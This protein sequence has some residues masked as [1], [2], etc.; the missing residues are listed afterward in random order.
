M[1]HIKHINE[2]NNDNLYHKI[3][4]DEW[5]SNGKGINVSD[6]VYKT[7]DNYV[8]SAI[9]NYKENKAGYSYIEKLVSVKDYSFIR[10]TSEY[11]FIYI[12][13][14]DD[15]YFDISVDDNYYKCDTVQ[16]VIN[17]LKG[18]S[19]DKRYK[20]TNESNSEPLYKEIDHNMYSKLTSDSK[21]FD[22]DTYNKF[23]DKYNA[24][25]ISTSND[26][27]RII[28]LNSEDYRA[29]IWYLDDEYFT[30][31]IREYEDTHSWDYSSPR[32][33]IESYYK[34]DQMDGVIQLLDTMDF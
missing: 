20:K 4:R 31:C 24:A 26:P 14:L 15:E 10:I 16:G 17:F 1:I 34:C 19:W 21:S 25:D 27:L 18:E 6:D 28:I 11:S 7:V 23:V 9:E 3:T 33:Y 8:R 12:K 5:S 22:E 29:Y 30:V 13:Q 2:Y 32:K